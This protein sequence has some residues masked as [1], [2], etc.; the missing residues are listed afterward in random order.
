LTAHD[1]G[2]LSLGAIQPT[3]PAH[4]TVFAISVSLKI[5][6]TLTLF[7]LLADDGTINRMGTGAV[8][9][10]EHDFYIGVIDNGA[11]RRLRSMIQPA[12]LD[13]SGRYERPD[14]VGP[15]CELSVAFNRAEGSD[16]V[17]QF[18]YGAES[19]G[20]PTDLREFVATAV[21]LT[22]AWAREQKAIAERAQ[23]KR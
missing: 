23:T 1:E 9:N 19:L 12:W 18:V 21:N 14:R 10:V 7:A 16:V 17:I 5:D 8:H 15:E 22:G 6:G 4:E 11:F 3:M 2:E 13:M 20:P